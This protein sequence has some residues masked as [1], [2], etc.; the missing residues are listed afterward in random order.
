MA[1][2]SRSSGPE[3]SKAMTA[4]EKMKLEIATEL[5]I[6]NY[7]KLD[8][9]DLPARVHGKI[10]G[11]MVKRMITNYEEIMANPANAHLISQSNSVAD[12]QLRQDKP[13]VQD[14]VQ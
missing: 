12:A 3:V 11:N 1:K 4:L 9:G 13:L 14:Y 5:G 10:G 2:T 8:K 6:P 7:D